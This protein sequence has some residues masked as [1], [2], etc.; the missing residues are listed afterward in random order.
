MLVQKYSFFRTRYS[1][2]GYRTKCCMSSD[3]MRNKPTSGHIDHMLKEKNPRYNYIVDADPIACC[4]RM[5]T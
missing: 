1:V 4:V 3:I 2:S 5:Y